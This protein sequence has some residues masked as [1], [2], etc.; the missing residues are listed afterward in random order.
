LAHFPG[1]CSVDPNLN[2]MQNYPVPAKWALQKGHGEGVTYHSLLD[3]LGFDDVIWRPYE[4]H[5][6]ILDFEEIFWYLGWIMCGVENVYRHLPKR[7]RRQ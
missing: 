1:F 7:V 6:E 2:Y 5:R 3:R 4:K